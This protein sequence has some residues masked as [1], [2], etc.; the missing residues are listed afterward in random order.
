MKSSSLTLLAFSTFFL[1]FLAGALLHLR[2]KCDTPRTSAAY[3]V[4]IGAQRAENDDEAEFLAGRYRRGEVVDVQSIPADGGS[5]ARAMVATVPY[6]SV[7]HIVLDCLVG[8]VIFLLG[9]VVRLFR[10]SHRMS[11]LYLLASTAVAIAVLGVKTI[12]FTRPAPVGAAL[13]AFFFFAY[14]L[15]PVLFYHFAWYFPSG[16]KGPSRLLIVPAY[17]LGVVLAGVHYW[18]YSRAVEVASIELFRSTLMVAEIQNAFVFVGLVAGISRVV[19]SYVKSATR[20]ER[21]KF[22]LVL[23]GLCLGTAPFVLFWILP[24]LFGSAPIIP[25][26]GFKLCLLLIP[27]SF[28]TSILR[29]RLMDLDFLVNRGAVYGLVIGILLLCYTFAVGGMT[30]LLG[31]NLQSISPFVAAG[32]TVLIA[33]LFQPLKRR[34]EHAIN[35]SLFR[36]EYDQRETLREITAEL[37]ECIDVA[38]AA[39]KITGR[40]ARILPVDRIGIFL[41]EPE[42][43]TVHAA[44]HT[45]FD[46]VDHRSIRFDWEGLRAT[47]RKPI[48]LADFVEPRVEIEAGD[49]GVFRRWG[50]ALVLPMPDR[51]GEALGFLVLGPKRSGIRFTLEDVELLEAAAREGGLAIERLQLQKQ[52]ILEHAE[53]ERLSELSRM[54]SFFVS[55]VSHDMKTPLTAI[56]MFAEMLR[57]KRR[58]DEQQEHYLHI[59]E[60][61]SQRL[62]RLIDNVLDYARIERGIKEYRF[63]EIN[64]TAVAQEVLSALQYVLE[65]EEVEVRCSWTDRPLNVSGD[66]DALFDVVANLISNAMKYSRAPK[67][68]TIATERSGAFALLRV[69]DN[70]V[71]IDPADAERVFEP[72]YR[73]ERGKSTGAGGL[74]LGLA[75]A[76]HTVEAHRGRISIAGEKDRGTT[77]TVQLPLERQEKGTPA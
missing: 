32:G 25:E 22:R 39:R 15:T 53:S 54:K 11:L 4:M 67:V 64:L 16:D 20:Q 55:S 31:E 21:Q 24:A 58:S 60:G 66:R 57:T 76:K 68:V 43:R 44:A 47:L 61:E 28:A 37:R 5:G 9:V 48:A 40:V 3:P 56:R 19:R 74:G 6:Y 73:T 2:E 77:F 34:V 12:A 62:T 27:V 63:T 17:T 38:D 75:I 52:L 51:A 33:L 1:L 30:L 36:I 14:G 70:G 71:G 69:G 50:M 13:G 10:P 35:V 49:A 65:A 42:R 46:L 41:F 23:F 18:L 45:G 26:M 72:F 7:R 29:Y 59:I 8:M